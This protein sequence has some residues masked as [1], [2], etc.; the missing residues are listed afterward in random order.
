VAGGYDEEAFLQ[1]V[2]EA[3]KAVEDARFLNL[4]EALTL[5]GMV[6]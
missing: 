3:S 4:Q 5:T 2:L 1:L 6:A